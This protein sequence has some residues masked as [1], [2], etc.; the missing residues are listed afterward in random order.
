M[1]R[2][3][4]Q[5]TVA[6]PIPMAIPIQQPMLTTDFLAHGA[7]PAA[8][9]LSTATMAG[10]G[11]L[12]HAQGSQQIVISHMNPKMLQQMT[13][14]PQMPLNMMP[15]TSACSANTSNALTLLQASNPT[16]HTQFTPHLHASG[17]PQLLSGIKTNVSPKRLI[18][19]R[20]LT[21]SNPLAQQMHTI[22]TPLPNAYMISSA[23]S[24]EAAAM[25]AAN[26]YANGGTSNS[27]TPPPTIPMQLAYFGQPTGQQQY[28]QHQTTTAAMAM[29]TMTMTA[30][31]NDQQTPQGQSQPYYGDQM[32]LHTM[33]VININLRYYYSNSYGCNL[34]RY[35]LRNNSYSYF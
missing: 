31:Q 16:P 25:S 29:A 23:Q 19:G 26:T 34:Q 15:E 2:A 27:C 18:D 33:Q 10:S 24:T 7:S 30:T 9:Q 22:S 8:T 21:N 17:S 12:K 20:L 28:Q 35:K 4:L 32:Q 14:F 13:V 6:V 5:P 1:P 3:I 11:A